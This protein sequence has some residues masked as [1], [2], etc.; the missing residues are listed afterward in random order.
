MKRTEILN[1][2]NDIFRNTLDN[3]NINLTEA[4]TA[5]DI[6]EWDSLSHIQLIVAIEKALKVRFKSSEIQAWQNV[7]Q[8]V[9]TI[10]AKLA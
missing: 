2:L 10:A 4:T 6:E 5:R 8:M 9:D 1:R 7:G 3:D